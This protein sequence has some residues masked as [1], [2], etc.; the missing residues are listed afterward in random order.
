MP[1]R[2]H[3]PG[4]VEALSAGLLGD[5]GGA[6]HLS[7]RERAV[8]PERAIEAR[9]RCEGDHFVSHVCL[10]GTCYDCLYLRFTPK[11]KGIT[12]N[13]TQSH[14]QT[15]STRNPEARSASSDSFSS[16]LSV[17]SASMSSAPANRTR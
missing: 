13:P 11:L 10:P 7:D 1:G 17:I 5:S 3:D 16:R 14:I 9:V 4:H 6:L 2:D 12:N 15:A 8:E